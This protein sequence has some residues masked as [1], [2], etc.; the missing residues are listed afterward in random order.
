MAMFVFVFFV[1]VGIKWANTTGCCKYL[2]I[3]SLAKCQENEHCQL[4]V[5]VRY[6]EELSCQIFQ[7]FYSNIL[8]HFA[9]EQY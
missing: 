6:S 9:P 4:L 1:T 7:F 3:W 5:V 8:I 2:N